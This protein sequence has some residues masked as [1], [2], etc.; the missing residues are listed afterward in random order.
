MVV[1]LYLAIGSVYKYTVNHA[2]GVQVIPHYAFWN[3]FPRLVKVSK[4][5][6]CNKYLL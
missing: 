2:R 1:S 5:L 4:S 6:C 3:E